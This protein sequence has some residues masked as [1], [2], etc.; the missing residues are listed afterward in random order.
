M[1]N[2]IGDALK[3]NWKIILIAVAPLAVIAI[4]FALPLKTVP[5]QTIEKYMTT[6]TQQQP[7]TVTETYTEQEPY[8]AMETRT[9]TVYNDTVYSTTWTH[10][11]TVDKPQSTF[12]VTME[13]YGGYSYS[14]PYPYW[15]DSDGTLPHIY[16]P[17]WYGNYGQPKITIDVSY[18]EEVTKYR[19]VTKTRNITKYREAQVQVEKERPVTTYVKKSLWAYIF[20]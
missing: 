14:Y 19:T 17:Y 4:I 2:K 20:E 13:N 8:K 9:E 12:T 7:Y 3:N 16:Y 11:F 15:F 18:Q 6:E 1:A 5:V 10:T